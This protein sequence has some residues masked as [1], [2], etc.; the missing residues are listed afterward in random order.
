MFTMAKFIFNIAYEKD[1]NAMTTKRK[2]I[3][4]GDKLLNI[5]LRH[6]QVKYILQK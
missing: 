5:K 1:L 2:I 3:L 6:Y 4:H